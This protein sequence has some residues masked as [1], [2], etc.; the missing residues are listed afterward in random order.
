MKKVIDTAKQQPRLFAKG[1]IG[2]ILA[3]ALGSRAIDTGSYWQYL[4]CLV[5]A[6]LGVK[7]LVR[8]FKK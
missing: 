1:V 3:Y 7:L 8:A 2:L 5:F 4:G 6:F